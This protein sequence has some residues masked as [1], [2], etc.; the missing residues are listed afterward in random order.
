MPVLQDVALEED[1]EAEAA[2]EARHATGWRHL[3]RAQQ[4]L[5]TQPTV[6]RLR[7][8]R[9]RP[10]PSRLRMQPPAPPSPMPVSPVQQQDSDD[11]EALDGLMLLFEDSA[12]P[13]A[14]PP[15]AS[16]RARPADGASGQHRSVLDLAFRRAR[17]AS[18]KAQLASM[19][20]QPGRKG[21][22]GPRFFH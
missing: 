10:G 20:A 18:M 19:N 15:P 13:P 9:P 4:I 7:A 12:P 1:P 5:Q 14:A 11:E 2:L 6:R 16:P 21:T 22:Q 17:V 8:S 3:Q